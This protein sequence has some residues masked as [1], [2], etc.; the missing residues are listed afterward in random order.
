MVGGGV[1]DDDG[2][3]LVDPA[4]GGAAAPV[5]QGDEVTIL[6]GGAE[7]GAAGTRDEDGLIE[8]GEVA[9]GEDGE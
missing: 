4:K 9:G 5:A 6:I 7:V 1:E 3:I 2:A 8:G